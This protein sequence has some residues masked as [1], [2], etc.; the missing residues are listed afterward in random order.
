MNNARKHGF[1]KVLN[2]AFGV[3]C[4]MLSASGV[5][6]Q[7]VTVDSYEIRYYAPGASAPTQSSTFAA[8]AATCN[9]P[10]PGPASSV[11][12]TRA[13]WDD[14]NNAGR[15]CIQQFTAGDVLLSLP[16]GN[17]EAALV[18]VN[19]AGASGESPR[20]PFSRLALPPVPSGLR[21]GR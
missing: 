8:A 13:I 18:A 4:M 17:Y 16:M 12:P 10:D 6:G 14:P 2:V 15:V 9:Q 20:G 19:Q 1:A 3:S 5:S 7:T 11:N 21:L